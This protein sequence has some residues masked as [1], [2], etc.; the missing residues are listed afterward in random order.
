MKWLDVL[1]YASKGNLTPP[2]RVEK[3]DEE[4]KKILTEGE[5]HVARK[6]GTEHAFTGECWN[7]P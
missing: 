2:K 1:Q 5:F 4:W 3:T 7:C 6:R